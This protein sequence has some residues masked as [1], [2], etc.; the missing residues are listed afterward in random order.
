MMPDWFDREIVEDYDPDDEANPSL[1]V[2]C[3]D[4]WDW[5]DEEDEGEEGE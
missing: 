3:E 4:E 5:R 1:L 2:E